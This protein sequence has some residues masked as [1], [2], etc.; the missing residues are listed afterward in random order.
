MMNKNQ[1]TATITALYS[2]LSREDMLSGDSLSIQNQRQIL[3]TYASQHGFLNIKHY[4]D[5]GT[6]GVH[7][8]RDGWQE[9]MTEVEQGTVCTVICKDMSRL[10]R[11]HIQ[12]GMYLEQFRQRNIRFIAIGNSIDSINPESMEYAPFINIMS[13]MYAKDTSKK[14]KAVAHSKGNTG[15]PLSYNA[16][17]GFKKSPTDKNVWLTDEYPAMIVK[18]IFQMAMDG[19]GAY[20]IARQLT[21]DKIEKPSYYFAN[22]R[23]VGAKPS[24]RDLSGPYAWNGGTIRAILSKPEYCGHTVN[25]RTYKESYKDKQSKW[26]P[27]EN[28]K[29]FENTHEAII[30][31]EVFDTV[32]RLRGT[33]RRIDTIGA[34]NPLTGIVFCA[35]CGAKMY[36]SRQSKDYYDENI[37]GKA[38]K[39]KTADFYTCSTYD[40]GKGAFKKVCASHF[41]RTV[42]IRELVL[43]AIRC[44]S[45]YVC[46]NEAEFIKKVREAS[47]VKQEET[48]KTHKKQLVKNERRIAE[49]DNLFKKV[50]ED[51][52]N[53]KLSD[54]RYEQLSGSYEIEQR[55]LKVQSVELQAELENF[56]ADSVKAD[57]FIEIVRHYT[58]F[59]ELTTPMLNEFIHRILVHEADKSSGERVQQVDIYFNFIGNF[60]VPMEEIPPTAEELA[61][62]EKHRKKLEYQREANRRWY[63]KKKREAEWHRAL[64]AG[65]ISEEELENR[66]Q[67]QLA[68]EETE[69]IQRK[70]R[71][72]QRR[73]YA[74]DWARQNRK[75]KRT[76]KAAQ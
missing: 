66:K 31:Q 65:E 42:V 15:K 64:E 20:Q 4:C 43:D 75:K 2:R 62:Q 59:E 67:E 14:I 21:E 63:D 58:E 12:V 1:A 18:Q 33:P 50:Y 73:E 76:E 72:E 19:M 51:N 69:K 55:E 36:N 28:W 34:A 26:N 53:G 13:E 48:A 47:T 57:N 68:Q 37:F 45:R 52:V 35:D 40:L 25:F 5:D 44:I 8:D 70:Q 24:S 30:E 27:K 38:Y 39:H 56:N 29:I 61:E 17:Y 16:I 7:F 10:G 46:E 60:I 3:E 54:E 22:N 9:L 32:Q 41:I 11:E 6:S 71:T 23:M 49:L 74:R